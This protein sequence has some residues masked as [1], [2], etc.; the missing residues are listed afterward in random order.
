[1]KHERSLKAEVRRPKAE[2]RRSSVGFAI[3]NGVELV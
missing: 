1:M 2:D 3:F